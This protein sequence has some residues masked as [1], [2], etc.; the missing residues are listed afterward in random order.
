M[1]TENLAEDW[2]DYKSMGVSVLCAYDMLKNRSFVFFK[3]DLPE[4]VELASKRK[5]L[6]GYNSVRFDFNLLQAFVGPRE[7]IQLSGIEHYD[8]LLETYKAAGLG[9]T[10]F[11]TAHRGFK[12]QDMTQANFGYGKIIDSVLA[13]ALWRAGK[14]SALINKCADDV[15]LCVELFHRILETGQ[16]IHPQNQLQLLKFRKPFEEI[17]G[18]L[19]PSGGT[20]NSALKEAGG[21]VIAETGQEIKNFKSRLVPEVQRPLFEGVPEKVVGYHKEVKPEGAPKSDDD[22]NR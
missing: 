17:A 16:L 12:L 5:L 4:F 10:K 22:A 11:T 9:T 15:M 21:R 19:S 3:E 1:E 13:P 14:I 8:I 6:V 20:G 2:N 7:C 18:T